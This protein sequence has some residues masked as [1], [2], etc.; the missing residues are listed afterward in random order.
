[1]GRLDE[2]MVVYWFWRRHAFVDCSKGKWYF[3][4]VGKVLGTLILLKDVSWG[5]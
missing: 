2:C 5:G 3:G 4:L 1:M